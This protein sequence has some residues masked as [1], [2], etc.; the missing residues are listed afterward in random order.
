MI[1]HRGRA[2]AVVDCAAMQ[3]W[4]SIRA[5]RN[6]RSFREERLS[7]ESLNRIVEAAWRSPSA[8]NRQLWSFVLCTDPEIIGAM[9]QTWE[10]A[11]WVGSAPAAV[12]L[13]NPKNPGDPVGYANPIS[14]DPRK[15]REIMQYDLGQATM[16]MMIAAADLGIGSGQASVVDTRLA[17]RVLGFPD[18]WYCGW[19]VAFGYPADR[20]LQPIQ[21]P[22]RKPLQQVI[23]R[24]RWE[25]TSAA[26]PPL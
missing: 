23:H 21:R 4:D 12:A 18:D 6:V 11:S 3:T 25:D 24:N 16:A 14:V 20:P 26:G 15:M 8:S 19:I 17:Q 2:S 10:A 13:L 5:R 1:G 9:A 22:R 7:D